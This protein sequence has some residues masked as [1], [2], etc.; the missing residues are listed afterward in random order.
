M[1]FFLFSSS[2]IHQLN[3]SVYLCCF[4][5][6]INLI[7][8]IYYTIYLIFNLYLSY[9]VY[10]Y[11]F[12]FSNSC[13]ASFLLSFFNKFLHLFLFFIMCGFVHK[14]TNLCVYSLVCTFELYFLVP[15]NWG[16]NTLSQHSYNFY[17]LLILLAFSLV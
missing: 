3:F 10:F 7:I 5:A 9:F 14:S 6:F 15:F 11:F 8:N 2:E 1:A 13:F 16:L 4:W 12:L 17:V